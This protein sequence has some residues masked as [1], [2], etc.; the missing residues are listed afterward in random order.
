MIPN[1]TNSGAESDSCKIYCD[2]ESKRLLDS[3]LSTK[4]VPEGAN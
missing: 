3:W 4:S 1:F 2:T